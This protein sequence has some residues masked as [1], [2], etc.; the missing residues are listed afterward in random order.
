MKTQ[1][2]SFRSAALI[3]ALLAICTFDGAAQVESAAPTNSFTAAPADIQPGA[4]PS[5]SP[6]AADGH[7]AAN[8]LSP[9]ISKA[10][11]SPWTTEV[12][13]LAQAGIEE[14]VILSYIDQTA[15]TFN[16]G[17]D[18][19]LHLKGLGVDSGLISAMLEHDSEV[20]LG[21]RPI[22]ASTVPET[23]P[24]FQVPTGAKDVAA[25]PVSLPASPMT[26]ASSSA[27][28]KTSMPEQSGVLSSFAAEPDFEIFESSGSG[29]VPEGGFPGNSPVMMA[30]AVSM[31]AHSL[32]PVRE[33]YSVELTDPVI[34]IP[35]WSR[36]PNTWVIEF[37]P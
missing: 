19:I 15:G 10:R 9:M 32:Y 31:S 1:R 34:V 16:L 36:P 37:G 20:V 22:A 29:S 12:L 4:P 30:H 27:P 33:P 17:A 25:G 24:L 35:A 18:Q 28:P 14:P 2:P 6:S 8:T 7:G 21:L 23:Q 13:K 26:A 3:P 5:V 11:L